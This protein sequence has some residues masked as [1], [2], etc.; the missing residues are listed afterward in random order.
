M[1]F[2]G[3]LS[4]AETII[5]HQ[6]EGELKPQLLDNGKTFYRG[7]FTTAENPLLNQNDIYTLQTTKGL[8]TKIKILSLLVDLAGGKV[9]SMYATH[10]LK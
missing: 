6:L 7:H 1:N 4:Q 8:R 10:P 2:H 3:Q 9:F 5:V